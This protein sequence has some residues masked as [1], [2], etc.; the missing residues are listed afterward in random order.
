MAT[1]AMRSAG[2]AAR[3]VEAAVE[4]SISLLVP[5]ARRPYLLPPCQMLHEVVLIAMRPS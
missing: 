5:K 3:I 4:A 2:Q 1:Q